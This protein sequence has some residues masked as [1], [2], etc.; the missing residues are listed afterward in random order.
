MEVLNAAAASPSYICK[1]TST[2][3]TRHGHKIRLFSK[4]ATSNAPQSPSSSL[5]HTQNLLNAIGSQVKHSPINAYSTILSALSTPALASALTYEEALQQGVE[6]SPSEASADFDLNGVTDALV[7]FASENSVALIAGV[8]LIA[9]PL[10]LTQVLLKP[11]T[12][13]TV[14]AEN[15][16]SKLGDEL[17]AQLL[18]IRAGE[19]IKEVGSPDI[20]AFKKRVVQVL[21]AGDD[22]SFLQKVSAK[23]KDPANTTLYILDKFAGNS[24]KVAKLVAENGFKAAFA[25]K[26]G[27]EGNRGWQ[28]SGLPW[29][30]PK[31]AFTVDLSSLK[32]VLDSTMEENSGL[33]PVTV[34]V[35]AATG[36]GLAAFSEVETLL[37]LLGSAALIQLFV[38]KLLFAEDRKRTLQQLEDFLDTKIAPKEL[39]D[40]LKDIGKALLPKTVSVATNNGAA[41]TGGNSV[42]RVEAIET[43]TTVPSTAAEP[44]RLPQPLSP[45]PHYPDFKPPTSP[46][47]S[48]P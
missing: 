27:A 21:Y 34:G 47:P 44:L 20:R 9:V 35:A 17:E 24:A 15:A 48:K 36:V 1:A 5:N 18:D 33:V 32:E 26:D 31:K 16:Y 11:N 8:V 14:S 30:V 23:F 12:Y 3:E 13:G 38:K 7:N 41:I 10:V 19:D 28:N 25:I 43:A 4:R 22:A 40:E 29:L 42:P 6:S 46:T 37:Q 39:V 45:Y 2:A